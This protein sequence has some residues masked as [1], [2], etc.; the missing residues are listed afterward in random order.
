MK[1]ASPIKPVEDSR[2]RPGRLN[3]FLEFVAAVSFLSGTG[4]CLTAG[5]AR[6]S[7]GD[8]VSCVDV[9]V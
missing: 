8:G 1:P 9:C 6:S 4:F 7:P 2:D 5:A 3:S